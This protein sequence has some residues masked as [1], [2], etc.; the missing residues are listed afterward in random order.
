[1]LSDCGHAFSSCLSLRA[2]LKLSWKLQRVLAPTGNIQVGSQLTHLRAAG[3]GRTFSPSLQ[4]IATTEKWQAGQT[5]KLIL[6]KYDISSRGRNQLT[7]RKQSYVLS[8]TTQ[9]SPAICANIQ[10]WDS[11][12][13]H[14]EFGYNYHLWVL[15]PLIC[16]AVV[17]VS[18]YFLKSIFLCSGLE[19]IF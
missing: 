11:N 10:K 8:S 13:S 7:Q 9:F 3:P 1:M 15:A 5:E 2:E 14:F 12:C 19:C 4:E 16:L 6:W 18:A 17:Y